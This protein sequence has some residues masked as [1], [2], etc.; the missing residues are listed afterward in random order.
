MELEC[1][2][3]KGDEVAGDIRVIPIIFIWHRW[4]KK[5]ISESHRLCFSFSLWSGFLLT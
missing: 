5:K 1:S 2:V 3:D 4:K